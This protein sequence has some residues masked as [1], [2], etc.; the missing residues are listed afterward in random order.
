MRTFDYEV[1]QAKVEAF[2][3]RI[4]RQDEEGE[5]GHGDDQQAQLPD[6]ELDY[7]EVLEDEEANG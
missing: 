6:V 3:C 4:S 1:V 7:G 5:K 2:V